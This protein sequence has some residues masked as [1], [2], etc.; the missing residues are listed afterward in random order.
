MR[1]V[2]HTGWWVI[3]SV[4]PGSTCNFFPPALRNSMAASQEETQNL[5]NCSYWLGNGAWRKFSSSLCI[6]CLL[7]KKL[8][9]IYLRI[10]AFISSPLSLLVSAHL[11]ISWNHIIH[12]PWWPSMLHS[13]LAVSLAWQA[14]LS[15]SG[16]QWPYITSTTVASIVLTNLQ[17]LR[18]DFSQWPIFSCVFPFCSSPW[19]CRLAHQPQTHCPQG[20]SAELPGIALL[21]VLRKEKKKTK[22]RTEL[23]Q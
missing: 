8:F 9:F 7:L 14:Q 11:S 10:R 18:K 22:T 19:L 21:R 6:P 12:S 2:A 4:G 16:G 20:R 17:L 1:E 15:A 23:N 13:S 3:I 5:L